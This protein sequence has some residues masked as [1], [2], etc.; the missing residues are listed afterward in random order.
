M[1]T[2][3][4]NVQVAGTGGVYKA[5]AG[6]ALPTDA[7]TPLSGAFDEMGL[8]SEDG[9]VESQGTDTKDIKAWQN[10]AVVR[11]V[12][13]SH[14]LTYA[15][16]ALETTGTTLEA[17]YGNYDAGHVEIKGEQDDPAVWVIEA[18]DG[19]EHHRIVIGSGQVTELGD[20]ARVNSDVT[21]YPFTLSC[22][23]D[24][25]GVKADVYYEEGGAS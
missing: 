2:D 10:G 16:T 15:F 12:R 22:Y 13:T 8:I 21:A 4:A 23:P 3:A 11:R 1:A 24:G 9:V 7:T 25:D 5:P 19:A 17:F 20:V 18:F 14:E 6:T